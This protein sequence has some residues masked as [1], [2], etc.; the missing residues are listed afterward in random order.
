M[1]SLLCYN[2]LQ[3]GR[4]FKY[5]FFLPYFYNLLPAKILKV[6]ASSKIMPC[7][8]CFVVYHIFEM[9]LIMLMYISDT[10]NKKNS[11]MC[12]DNLAPHRS[13]LG[14]PDNLAT[15]RNTLKRP[16]M[17]GLNH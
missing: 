7:R 12:V 13:A 4:V 9:A 15:H 2:I 8:L 16:A 11:S 3:A 1:F 17:T 14:R 5:N 6:S 10:R